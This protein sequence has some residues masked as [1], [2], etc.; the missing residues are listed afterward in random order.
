MGMIKRSS[1]TSLVGWLVLAIALL[2]AISVTAYAMTRGD[3]PKPPKRSL[4]S[5]VHHAL[6]AKPVS[7][8]TADFRVDQHLL[9][10]TSTSLS[11]NPL[12]AGATGHV[13]IGGGHARLDLSSQLGTASIA[14]D[15]HKVTLYDR[16][17]H[18]AYV[19]PVKHHE[20]PGGATEHDIPSV[21]QISHA[22]TRAAQFAVISGAIP[23]NVAGREAYTVHVSPRHDGGLFGEFDLAWDAAHGVPLRFAI[24]P[25][26]SSQAAISIS[27][28]HIRFGSV[29]ASALSATPPAGTK[30]VHVHMPSRH[31]RTG[32][33]P[34]ATTAVGH[35]AASK[36]VGFSVAAPATL[37]GLPQ[38]QVRAVGIGS[39]HAAVVTYGRG[40]GTV[41]LVEQRKT[42]KE[43]PLSA[44]PAVTVNGI[45]AHE[46]DTTLGSVIQWS[47]GGVTYTIAGSQSAERI[48]SAAKSLT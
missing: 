43:S 45:R 28:T 7:G 13:W 23:S 34:H 4:A 2:S 35:A 32:Q 21:A 47:R 14:F 1:A 12:L 17:H 26:G 15:G 27:V 39:H 40:L 18:V 36:A 42:G 25:R 11:S 31:E 46:L 9:A 3:G 29:Q 10:G 44:L 30:I 16:K 5:A 8:L 6:A 22:L 33:K 38:H 41:F 19:L 48:M 20:K 24:F 37:A